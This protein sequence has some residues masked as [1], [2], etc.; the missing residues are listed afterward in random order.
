MTGIQNLL[1]CVYNFLN[2][3]LAYNYLNLDLRQQIRL[4]LDAA[5]KF[6]CSALYAVTKHVGNRH[7]GYADLIH[8]ALKR[9]ELILLKYNLDLSYLMLGEGYYLYRDA[10]RQVRVRQEL[11]SGLSALNIFAGIRIVNRNKV[12]NLIAVL[13]YVKTLDFF[14]LETPYPLYT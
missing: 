13:A 3:N 6:C 1:G 8:S 5:I 11:K 7:T 14:L 9:F 2:G 4:N 12:S 10:P